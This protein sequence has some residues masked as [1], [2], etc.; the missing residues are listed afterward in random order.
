M[1]VFLFPILNNK[2]KQS[3]VFNPLPPSPLSHTH[4]QH[5]MSHGIV[6]ILFT[7]V[8]MFSEVPHVQQL[9]EMPLWEPAQHGLTPPNQTTTY[10]E[11]GKYGW[12]VQMQATSGTGCGESNLHPHTKWGE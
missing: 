8:H 12:S 4:T 3:L 9:W 2:G 10:S 7:G 5:Q 6:I 1:K 11:Y